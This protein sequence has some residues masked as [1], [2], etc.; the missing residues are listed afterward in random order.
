[1]KKLKKRKLEFFMPMIPPRTTK[2]QTKISTRG[3]RPLFYQ[4][5]KLT[6][7]Q[8][9][10]EAHLA[11]YVPKEK[12][13]GATRL[14]V[15]WCYSSKTKKAPAWKTTKPDTDNLQKMLKDLMTKL[16]YWNDDAL[17]CSEY[18]EKIWNDIPGIYI[19]IEEL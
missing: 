9:K 13:V 8:L 18:I 12:F 10:L 3:K 15:K 19:K 14:E 7:A 17:V 5:E 4:D 1:M 6:A 16:G 11:Q 2:Q